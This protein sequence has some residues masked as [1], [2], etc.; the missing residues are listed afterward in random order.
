MATLSD[1]LNSINTTKQSVM[2]E[3]DDVSGYPAF[4]VLRSLSYHRNCIGLC[5][6]LNEKR[7][8]DNKMHYDFLLGTIPRGKKFAKWAKPE[9]FDDVDVV[10][11]YYEV[12]KSTAIEYLQLLP[13]EAVK[14]IRD[15]FDEGGAVKVK[16]K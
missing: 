16:K 11:R 10:A 15:K 14:K 4:V 2:I 7:I 8:Q 5:Q 12:S 6:M 3:P 9:K 1:Y 13:E